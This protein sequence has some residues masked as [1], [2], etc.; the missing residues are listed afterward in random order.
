MKSFGITAMSTGSGKTSVTAALLYR[1]NKSVQIKIGPDFI[2]PMVLSAIG[3]E[4]GYNMD[5][6]LQGNKYKKIPEFA[7]EQNKYAIYEGVMGFYDS[8]MGRGYSTEAYFERLKIP[9]ILVVDVMKY[10]ESIYYSTIGFRRRSC[11]G[12]ILNRYTTE[13]HLEMVKRVFDEHGVNVIGSIPYREDL[14]IRERH[15]GISIED[16]KKNAVEIGKKISE[17]IDLDFLDE[18]EDREYARPDQKYEDREDFKVAIGMDDAFNFYYRD[19]LEYLEKRFDV[20]YF[21]PLKNEVPDDPDMVYLGGG[22]PELHGEQLERAYR[23]KEFLRDFHRSG[24]KIYSECGGTMFLLEN[25]KNSDNNYEMAGVFKGSSWMEKRPVLSYTELQCES[26][27]PFYSRGSTIRGHE[28]HYS[29]IRTEER[30][31]FNVSRGNGIDGHDGIISK[32]ALGFYTHV[33]MM[34]YGD[35]IFK[36]LI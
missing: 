25:M 11:I 10:G 5:R 21:S 17:Y 35:K 16:G 33:D 28:F 9:Y 32:N 4:K 15:L 24:G 14:E 2:D 8:G 12:V 7:G 34:V 18:I 22:Y 19:A 13:R 36:N 27:N 30:M 23:T 26:G 29:R 1:I 3:G 20:Q 31:A 6:W